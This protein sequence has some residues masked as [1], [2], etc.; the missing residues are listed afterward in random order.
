MVHSRSVQGKYNENY[1]LLVSAV[2][3]HPVRL[4]ANAR[5]GTPRYRRWFRDYVGHLWNDDRPRIHLPVRSPR[6]GQE[7]ERSN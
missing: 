7:R 1:Q 3:D 4:P 5:Q 2:N 6:A